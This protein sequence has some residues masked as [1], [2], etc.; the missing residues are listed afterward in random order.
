MP[1]SEGEDK[2]PNVEIYGTTQYIHSLDNYFIQE[3]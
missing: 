3:K 1:I 2:S